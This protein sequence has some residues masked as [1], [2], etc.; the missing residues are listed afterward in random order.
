MHYR[1]GFHNSRQLGTSTGI[2]PAGESGLDTKNADLYL[3]IKT[4]SITMKA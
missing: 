3:I 2:E 4:N 1:T